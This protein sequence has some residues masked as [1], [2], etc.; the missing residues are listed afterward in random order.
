MRIPNNIDIPRSEWERL[1]DE[2]IFNEQHREMLKLNLLDGWTYERL[3]EKFE[4]STRQV[5]RIIPKLQN[6]L[7]KRI[8]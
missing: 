7:F 6:Q 4:M 2:W 8:K 1:I 5:A 3:S